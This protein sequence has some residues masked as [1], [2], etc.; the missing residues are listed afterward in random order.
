VP[1]LPAKSGGSPFDLDALP[2]AVLP[3][4]GTGTGLLPKTEKPAESKPVTPPKTESVPPPKPAEA[5]APAPTAPESPKP[6]AAAQTS[7]ILPPPVLPLPSA[8][9]AAASG[10]P[11][12][13]ALTGD[14]AKSSTDVVKEAV[15][16]KTLPVNAALPAVPPPEG[17]VVK[18]ELPEVNV[19]NPAATPAPKSELPQVV[20]QSPKPEA[21]PASAVKV[22]TKSAPAPTPVPVVPPASPKPAME[23]KVAPV[24]PPVPAKL[25][26]EAKPEIKPEA[27]PVLPPPPVEVPK[28][29]SGVPPLPPSPPP[30]PGLDAAA[31]AADSSAPTKVTRTLSFTKGSS[32]LSE[33]T[34][35]DLND[36]V[37]KLKK[38]GGKARV[39]AYASGTPEESSV[40]NKVALARSLAVRA[41]LI[42]Q[43]VDQQSIAVQALGNKV[44][45]GDADRV[46]VYTK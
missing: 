9:P 23:P 7:E 24:V 36:V 10:L 1:D 38:E 32:E 40:A 43:G 6:P 14:R 29:N 45:S 5:T 4:S 26:V 11:S 37:A 39:V 42:R 20:H 13:D 16:A 12:L 44:P 22:E 30:V 3:P 27:K 46:D 8:A 25:P 18:R 2:P 15:Q 31:P 19:N 33:D 21:K 17:P 28:P 41:Y 34:I 35:S